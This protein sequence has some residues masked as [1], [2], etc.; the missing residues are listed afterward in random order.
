MSKNWLPAISPSSDTVVSV[1]MSLWMVATC[2]RRSSLFFGLPMNRSA[3][4]SSENS[5]P[6]WAERNSISRRRRS[7]SL[8]VWKEA[9]FF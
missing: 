2:L 1:L 8:P 5:S 4:S 6:R 3:N 7:T 9:F